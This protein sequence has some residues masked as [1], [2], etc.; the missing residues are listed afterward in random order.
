MH[1]WG[2]LLAE[3]IQFYAGDKIEWERT[4]PDYTSPQT[5]NYVFAG[6]ERYTVQAVESPNGFFTTTISTTTSKTYEPGSYRLIGYIDDAGDRVAI[7]YDRNCQILPNPLSASTDDTR[8]FN[9]RM[10]DQLEC[11]LLGRAKT[12]VAQYT[13][14]GRQIAKLSL[15]QI[16]KELGRFK[17]LLRQERAR[18]QVRNGGKNP[19]RILFKG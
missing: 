6:P 19:L 7:V 16:S 17:S 13:I 15:E 9:E 18:E 5:L 11:L 3:P 12:D 10:V 2:F 4:L 1:F 8:S 14:G